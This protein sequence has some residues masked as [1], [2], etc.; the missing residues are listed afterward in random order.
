METPKIE[1]IIV[2]AKF[3]DGKIRQLI[4]SDKEQLT[5]LSTFTKGIK[6]IEEPLTNISW[7]SDIKLTT[8]F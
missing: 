4:A 5:L 3:T 6:V 7:E 1:N 2:L 8:Y